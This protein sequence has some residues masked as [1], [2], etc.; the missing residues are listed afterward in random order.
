MNN[1]PARPQAPGPR[2]PG[3]A[4]GLPARAS[5]ARGSIGGRRSSICPSMASASSGYDPGPEGPPPPLPPIPLWWL[6]PRPVYHEFVLKKGHFKYFYWPDGYT[7][8]QEKAG[9]KGATLLKEG[10]WPPQHPPGLKPRAFRLVNA[11]VARPFAAPP[12]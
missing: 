11:S 3:P 10:P 12:E 8:G 6:C 4:P 2:S 1:C 9:R 7:R 5:G